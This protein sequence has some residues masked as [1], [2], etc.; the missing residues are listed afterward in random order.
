MNGI[1][2][3]DEFLFFDM[4]AVFICDELVCVRH[5]RADSQLWQL[6]SVLEKAAG[7]DT[8]GSQ[9]KDLQAVMSACQMTYLAKHMPALQNHILQTSSLQKRQN[10]LSYA[11]HQSCSHQQNERDVICTRQKAPG[12]V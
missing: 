12:D 11:A 8:Q 10:G 4:T 1:F 2:S 6:E 5:L 3:A 7:T 9:T